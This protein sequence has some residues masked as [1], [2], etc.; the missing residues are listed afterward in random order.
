M[1]LAIMKS[2]TPENNS[3][4]VLSCESACWTHLSQDF[5]SWR[6]KISANWLFADPRMPVLS[7]LAFQRSI[8][9]SRNRVVLVLP[10]ALGH[11]RFGRQE[12]MPAVDQSIENDKILSPPKKIYLQISSI[13]VQLTRNNKYSLERRLL[14]PM[15][16]D[17][18]MAVKISE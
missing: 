9:A 1:Y 14:A 2:D 7:L 16:C 5:G 13:I 18:K 6:S 4:E 10:V 15:Q 3:L 12:A 17:L 8:V 11:P